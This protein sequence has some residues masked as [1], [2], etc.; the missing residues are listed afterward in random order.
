MAVVGQLA[1]GDERVR[2]VRGEGHGV[3]AARN[4][5]LEHARGELVAYL[6]SDNRWL[7]TYLAHVVAALVAAPEAGATLALQIVVDD[8]TREWSLRDDDHPVRDLERLNFIDLNAYAHR[9]ALVDELGGFDESLRRLSDW[10]LARRYTARSPVTRLAVPGSVYRVGLPDQISATEPEA[11]YAHLVRVK[12]L[13]REAAGLRVLCAEWHYPQLSETYVQADIEGLKRLGAHVEVWS[14]ERATA[15]PFRSDE[16][17]HRGELARAIDAVQP[18][19]VLTHWLNIGLDLAPQVATSGVPFVVRGHGF[20]FA[21]DVAAG[22]AALPVGFDA[23]R[24]GPSGKKDRELVL[25]AGVAIPTKDYPTFFEVAAACPDHRFVLCLVTAHRRE[26]HVDELVA[27]RDAAGAPVDIR[28]DVPPDEMAALVAE[29]GIYLHTHGTQAPFGMPIS[30]AE[31][32]AT[33]CYVLARDL[34]GCASYL[35]S[36]G[37]CYGS[38]EQAAGLINRSTSWDEARWRDVERRAVDRAFAGLTN[39]DVARTMVCDWR[40]LGLITAPVQV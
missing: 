23:A 5:A 8:T 10:D 6:D 3:A 9:R 1:D 37:E 28:V 35:R 27:Q 22:L 38:A 12:H 36:G 34:P 32:M 11:Y 21:P 24:Y 2:V 15:A 4:R 31:A 19:V 18:H 30:I 29:A 33:G 14:D 16:I 17:V 25:R 13:D 39:L 7:P 20:E 26:E 40:A